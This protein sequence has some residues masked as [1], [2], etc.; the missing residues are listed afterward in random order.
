MKFEIEFCLKVSYI[1]INMPF[2]IFYFRVKY[3]PTLNND[4]FDDRN[5][6]AE[7]LAKDGYQF[8]DMTGGQ[9]AYEPNDNFSAFEHIVRSTAKKK[10]I[11]LQTV[12]FC[13]YPG[14][15]LFH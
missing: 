3:D 15:G 9:A 6:I 13:E 2:M 12:T 14:L 4:P 11:P 10:R 7:E 5:V 1:M 8:V